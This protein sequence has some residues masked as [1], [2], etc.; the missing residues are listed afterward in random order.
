MASE[1]RKSS[2]RLVGRRSASQSNLLKGKTGEGESEVTVE[3]TEELQ[4]RKRIEFEIN[5]RRTRVA[6]LS[7]ELDRRQAELGKL[8]ARSVRAMVRQGEVASVQASQRYRRELKSELARLQSALHEARADENRAVERM[9]ALEQE[10]LAK[11]AKVTERVQEE[12]GAA[13]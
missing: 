4:Y 11:A 2:G 1:R 8:F 5:E 3:S 9:R 7:A 13:E 10:R 6:Q 12:H